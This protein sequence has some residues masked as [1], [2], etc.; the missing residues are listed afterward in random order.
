MSTKKSNFYRELVLKLLSEMTLGSLTL[1]LPEG[2]ELVFGRG[3]GSI[4]A[5]AQITSDHFFKKCVL[6]GDV[7]F[8]EAYVDGDW[9]T[10]DIEAVIAWMILNVENHPTLMDTRQKSAPV[11]FLGF[12]NQLRHQFK[13]NTVEKSRKNISA[14]YDLGNE[15][16]RLFLDP[17]MTYS[18]AYFGSGLDAKHETLQ[19]AQ[20][21]KYSQL[22]H[23]LQLKASDHVLEIGSGWGGFAIHAAKH[24]YSHVTTITIS[25][26]QYAYARERFKK[27]GLADKIDIQ[28]V[29]YRHLKG[30]YDKIA[31]IEMIEAVGHEHLPAY[32]S[33]CH[34]LLKKD[35]L[36]GLQMILAPDHR[37]E[38]FRQRPDWIQKHIFPGGLLPSFEAILK[39]LRKTGDLGLLGYEDM[40]PFYAKT[41]ALWRE[42]FGRAQAQVRS[43]GFDEAFIRKWNYYFSYC[44]AAFR[45]RNISVVQA[46]FTR[47]NNH[48]LVSS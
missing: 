38:S 9:Q 33:Q 19:E 7:G 15:F 12:L 6:Y 23:K 44:E 32:F 22:C 29:D 25:R 10:D 1:R 35:G 20:E 17:G 4:Q 3:E 14:H 11:N 5:R 37:Y 36:L 30:Q 42:N 28:L 13:A 34:R 18:S 43:L 2:D 40:T 47:P 46:V 8:G 31:S 27:E 48:R 24:F 16:F 41:L 21:R 45:M 39:A 26:E